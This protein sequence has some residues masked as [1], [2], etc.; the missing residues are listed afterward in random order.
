MTTYFNEETHKY[1]I[2]DIEYPSVTEICDPISFQRLD[3]L[4]KTLLNRARARGTEV[5]EMCEQYALTEEISDDMEE[6][7]YAPYIANFIE[8]FRTYQVEV[9]F[10]E[11]RL[12]S[13]KLGYC[14]TCDL[15]C[16]ID[17]KLTLVDYKATSAI[18]KKSLSVQLVG[19][20]KLLK[21]YGYDVE[22]T[23]VLHLK[24]DGYVYKPITLDEEWFEILLRHN[25]KMRGK[26][27]GK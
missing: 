9:L 19:Y 22:E 8:W 20:K 17:G 1:Y 6:S 5:H 18:D 14:G 10:T 21:E 15:L 2:D 24:K 25:Q 13:T 12:Y 11:K 4:S 7:E 26:Y 16:K 23:M 27:N 3:E